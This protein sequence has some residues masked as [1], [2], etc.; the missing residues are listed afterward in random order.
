MADK[1]M[2]GKI[3]EV[4]E[5]ARKLWLDN[6]VAEI[7]ATNGPR[8]HVEVEDAGEVK[9][10]ERVLPSLEF[11]NKWFDDC[12]RE[13]MYMTLKLPPPWFNFPIDE[14][15]KLLERFLHDFLTLEEGAEFNFSD[16]MEILNSFV[17]LCT[18]L[19][20]EYTT[21]GIEARIEDLGG[22]YPLI[23]VRAD[24]HG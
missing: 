5:R 16:G 20:K 2:E 22:D 6:H 7:Y 12:T 8:S 1:E 23:K 13:W 11:E 15:V 24:W 4:V 9:E 3:A 14:A 10:D 17:K 19:Y 18:K 21:R